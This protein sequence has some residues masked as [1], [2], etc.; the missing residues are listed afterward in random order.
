[1]TTKLPTWSVYKFL[2]LEERERIHLRW[3]KLMGKDPN[4]EEDV[5]EFFDLV[6]A[7]PEVDINASP[8]KSKSLTPSLT[9]AGK[10]RGRPRKVQE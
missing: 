2:P 8:P 5:N 1:M 9:A 7:V 6:D 10:T 4:S 3:C